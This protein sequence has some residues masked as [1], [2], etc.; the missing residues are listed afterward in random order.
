[1]YAPPCGKKLNELIKYRY[2]VCDLKITRRVKIIVEKCKF[3][4]VTVIFSRV[5]IDINILSLIS[6]HD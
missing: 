1:M 6:Y 3:L 4:T 5:K 2:I